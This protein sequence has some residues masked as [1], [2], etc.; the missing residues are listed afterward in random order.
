MSAQARNANEAWLNSFF[1]SDSHVDAQLKAVQDVDSEI[2]AS[3]QRWNV[4]RSKIL[5]AARK[6]AG[7]ASWRK[8]DDNL[9]SIAA[10]ESNR[11]EHT[12]DPV[13][14]TME[15]GWKADTRRVGTQ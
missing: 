3:R 5:P 11:L 9:R 7:S 10:R 13:V 12:I 4:I 14:K 6:V 1:K 15:Q 2:D 8:L